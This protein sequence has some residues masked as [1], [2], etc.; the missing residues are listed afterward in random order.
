MAKVN[1]LVVPEGVKDIP[2][3]VVQ[4]VRGNILVRLKSPYPESRIIE[5]VIAK[6]SG[7]RRMSEFHGE[8]VGLPKDASTSIP[9]EVAVGDR[10]CFSG[11]AVPMTANFERLFLISNSCVLAVIRHKDGSPAGEDMEEFQLP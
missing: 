9:F 11:N 7:K 8:V 3:C 1:S 4:P 2:E 5:T 10:L 6:A